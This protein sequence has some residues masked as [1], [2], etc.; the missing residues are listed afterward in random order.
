MALCIMTVS[1]ILR[2]AT[3]TILINAVT[4]KCHLNLLMDFA[5][6]NLVQIL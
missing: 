1:N 6:Y 5:V 4:N 3:D 2:F